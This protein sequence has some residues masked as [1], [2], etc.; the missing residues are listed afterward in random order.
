MPV[1]YR[2]DDKR[3]G[4]PLATVWLAAAGRLRP[5]SR[6]TTGVAREASPAKRPLRSGCPPWAM[7]IL[8]HFGSSDF[9]HGSA[10][11]VRPTRRKFSPPLLGGVCFLFRQPRPSTRRPPMLLLGAE[12]GFPGAN[13]PLYGA[14]RCR[15][16]IPY[17]GR[18][19]G[20]P[21]SEIANPHHRNKNTK[22]DT[23]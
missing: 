2:Y 12:S 19:A 11:A 20:E 17:T 1:R 4:C 14:L 6:A 9:R 21:N 3:R 7:S 8:P 18:G 10:G 5:S 23:T 22:S 16:I 15:I 13:I